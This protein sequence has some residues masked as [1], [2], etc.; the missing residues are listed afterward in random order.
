MTPTGATLSTP[1]DIISPS[2]GVAPATMA[3]AVGIRMD[4]TSTE[5]RFDSTAAKNIAIVRNPSHAVVIACVTPRA[6]LHSPRSRE[7]RH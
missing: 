5:T 3:I 1:A 2:C 4:A 7:P 6:R